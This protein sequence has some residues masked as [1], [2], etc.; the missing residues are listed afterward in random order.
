[1]GRLQTVKARHQQRTFSSNAPP[2]KASL[3]SPQSTNQGPSVQVCKTMGARF[4]FKPSQL[5][6]S[7]KQGRMGENDGSKDPWNE[8]SDGPADM[9]NPRLLTVHCTLSQ[10]D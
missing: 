8:D 6:S 5:E 10:T 3:I 1:M 2:L 9:H 4:S 7:Q